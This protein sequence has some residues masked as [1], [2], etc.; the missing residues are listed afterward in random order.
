MKLINLFSGVGGLLCGLEMAG[1]R[2]IFANEILDHFSN[3]PES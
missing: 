2:P 1:F 3:Q